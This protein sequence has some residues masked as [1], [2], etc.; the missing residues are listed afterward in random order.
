MTDAALVHS[1]TQEGTPPAPG[2]LHID[3]F[4][5]RFNEEGPFELIDGE[6]I[7]KLPTGRPH[8]RLLRHLFRLLDRYCIDNDLG[9]VF[10]DTTFIEELI[11]QWVKGS[12]LPDVMFYEQS[13]YQAMVAE[14][15]PGETKPF[16]LVPDLAVEVVSPTD[17]VKGLREGVERYLQQ[18]VRL[19]WVVDGFARQ[20]DV[21][22]GDER[23][24]LH[25]DDTVLDGG[26]VL[27]GFQ[28]TL[29]ALF[30]VLDV[31]KGKAKSQED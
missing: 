18:G 13:R 23:T 30:A 27:P 25:G 4:M 17:S 7:P 15:E 9:E 1:T 10:Q 28:T 21:Y 6:R 2:V 12:R 5:R 16:D 22:H 19:V 26:D 14:E 3:D 29:G 20:V 31:A 8:A 11:P 24:V